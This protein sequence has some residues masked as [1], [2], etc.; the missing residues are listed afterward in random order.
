MTRQ[1]P[2]IVAPYEP[3]PWQLAPLRDRSPV[4]L[5]TGAAGGGKSKTAAEKLHAYMLHYQLATGLLIRK[6]RASMIN[7]AVL[8]MERSIIGSPRIARHYPSKSRFEYRNGSLLAYAGLDDADALDRLRS[9]GLEGRVDVAW[10]EE[11]NELSETD[12]NA[13]SGRMRG[14]AAPWQQVILTCNP[15][16]PL[17]WIKRRLIDRKEAKVYYSRDLDNP[18]NPPGYH[19]KLEGLTGIDRSRL[20]DGQWVQAA[21]LIYDTWNEQAN[22]TEEAE[23]I[24]GAGMVI[25]AVDDGYSAGAAAATRGIDL[26]TGM[27]VADAHPRVFLLA[28]LKPDGHLDIFAEHAA[29]LTLSNDQIETVKALGYPTPEY[30]AIGPGFAELKGR[31]HAAGIY[32]RFAGT[33]V[34]ESIKEVRRTLA[35]DENGWRRIRV[36]PRCTQLRLEMVSYA[37]DPNTGKPIKAYD[38]AVDALRYIVQ[39]LKGL[40]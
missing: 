18:Y 7:G 2:K 15:D 17:H 16:S 20:L 38:H 19:A 22:V 40:V 4:I 21:G 35:A 24:P 12:Y 14:I 28:Q 31:L 30:A 25:W 36:H 11:A 23:Y 32:T 13:V 29:C 27:F 9:I 8:M 34:E 37:A 6:T 33:S 10:I 26:A 39:S 1:T 3:L 5:L